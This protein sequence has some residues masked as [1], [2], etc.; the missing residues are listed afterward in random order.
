M[1]FDIESFYP[2]ISE[3]L[4]N[5]AI[6]YA[7]N[8]VETPDHDMIVISHSRRSSLF[9]ENEP[10]VKKES[11]KD[12]D[13]TMGSN[14]VAEISKLVRLLML[15]KLVHLFQDNSVQ[16]HRDDGLGAPRHLSGPETERICKNVAKIFKNCGYSITSKTNLKRGDYLNVKSD[17]Q[18][19]SYK[20]YRKPDKLPV[21]I[22]KHSNHPQTIRN[23]L[24]K[25]IAKTISDLSYIFL[26][27]GKSYEKVVLLLS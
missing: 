15:S 6:Q 24:L 13:V 23:E 17:L 18:N 27:I 1:V 9:H 8:I 7:K 16:L 20:P 21:Y 4:F 11:N 3:K 22:H 5:E 10:W 26:Y 25:S 12:F 2:S 19:N 14:D